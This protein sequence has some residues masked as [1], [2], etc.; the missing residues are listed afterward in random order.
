MAGAAS[1]G[2]LLGSSKVMAMAQRKK[3]RPNFIFIFADDLGWG[4]L[5]CYGNKQ[6]KTP[7]LD[8]MAKNGTLFTQFYVPAPSCSPSRTGIMTSHFPAKHRIHTAIGKHKMNQQRGMPDWLD[9]KV[10]TVTRLLKKAGYVTGHF[11]KWHLGR[12]GGPMPEDY[13]VDEYKTLTGIESGYKHLRREPYFWAK[14]TEYFVDDTIKFIEKHKDEPFYV[15]LWTLIPHATL[16]PTEEQ[17]EPYKRYAPR[18]VP[19]HG[20]KK[21]YYASVTNLDTEIGRLIHKLE[22]LGLMENTCVIFSSDNG[23]EDI[24]IQS[25]THSGVGST[26]PFRGRKRSLYEGGIRLPF[27]VEWDGKIPTD[28]VDDETIVGG[29]DFLPT[30]CSLA[31][32]KL[33]RDLKPDGEDM[34][35]AFLGKSVKRK[36]PLMWERRVGVYG[37]WTDKS[38]GM[39]IREGKWK[40][41]MNRDKSRIELYDIPN[42][43]TEV[44]NVARENPDVI[45]KL[46]KKL[47]A[48]HKTLPPGPYSELTGSNEYPWPGKKK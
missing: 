4:D 43:P 1:A 16:H 38:P 39:A 24:G 42:D 31:G 6:I 37:W 29:V 11:G 13:G 27:I 25:A 17:M 28:R 32:V 5:G 48:W 35:K 47:L 34:S 22:R 3:Q 20:A 30:I 15:N 46:S 45:N 21:I 26:G 2:M 40:L 44:N 36:K 41:L 12:E 9:P 33:P 18:G 8:R 10:H 7:N 19:Y 14:T 23:P